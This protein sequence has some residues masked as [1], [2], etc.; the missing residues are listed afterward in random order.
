MVQGHVGDILA[1]Q[2]P[3]ESGYLYPPGIWLVR[4]N[5]VSFDTWC[6]ILADLCYGPLYFSPVFNLV[7][8]G[9]FA[10]LDLVPQ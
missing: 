8:K 2:C 5:G 7:E 10:P 9:V 1:L 3:E 6:L 4:W